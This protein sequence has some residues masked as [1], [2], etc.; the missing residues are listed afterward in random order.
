MGRWLT[1]RLISGSGSGSTRRAREEKV[2][3]G[4]EVE[5]GAEVGAREEG[6]GPGEL[7]NGWILFDFYRSEKGLVEL[8][9]AFNFL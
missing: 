9:L 7:L 1:A 8:L 6:A 5:K 2:G 3:S 4:I